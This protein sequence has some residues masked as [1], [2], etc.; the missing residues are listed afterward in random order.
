MSYDSLKARA[1]SICPWG[2]ASAP[3]ALRRASLIEA[4]VT[5]S[6][7]GVGGVGAVW[8]TY[9]ATP[10]EYRR[11]AEIAASAASATGVS[12]AEMTAALA[13]VAGFKA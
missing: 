1:A 10:G 8:D 7:G 13:S 3:L 5:D 4:T 11:L 9:A 2:K 6:G 12:A